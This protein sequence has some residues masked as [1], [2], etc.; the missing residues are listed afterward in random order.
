MSTKSTIV[1]GP[2]FHLYH[3]LAD[4]DSV[5]LDLE[6]VSFEESYRRVLVP[7]PVHIWEVIRAYAGVDLR[8]AESS[9]E[10][11]RAA[12][13][14]RVDERLA[15]AA[16]ADSETVARL[17][18]AAVYGDLDTPRDEQIA[19]GLRHAERER[20]HQRQIFAAIDELRQLIDTPPPP[21]ATAFSAA[22]D[23][24][25]DERADESHPTRRQ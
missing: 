16:Q 17:M 7:I 23:E 1:S 25:S 3:D 15:R 5:S 19:R 9:D 14:R 2:S 18:G 4:E 10:D 24:E 6:G 21:F 22:S 12:V 11:L 8:L 20:T 13:E